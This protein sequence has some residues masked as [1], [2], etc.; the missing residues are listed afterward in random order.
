[1]I[2]GI[3]G[4]VGDV[5][6]QRL[7]SPRAFEQ[8]HPKDPSERRLWQSLLGWVQRH[9]AADDLAVMDAGVRLADVQAA[10]LEVICCAWRPTSRLAATGPCLYAGKAANRSTARR[11]A[12]WSAATR[13]RP[14]PP[15]LPIRWKSK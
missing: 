13:A 6:G 2:F 15:P 4:V 7:A 14:S 12:R 9:L 5:G 3:I 11:F 10:E 1:M 8:V